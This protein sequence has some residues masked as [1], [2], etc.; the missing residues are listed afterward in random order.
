M[1]AGSVDEAKTTVSRLPL[2]EGDFLTFD[3]I[4][5]GPL[6]PVGRLIQGK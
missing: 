2:V 3:F 1:N 4:P 5:V 6:A